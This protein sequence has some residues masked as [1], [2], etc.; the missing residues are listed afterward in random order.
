MQD[1][2]ERIKFPGPG[3]R[4][5][6]SMEDYLRVD[7]ISAS[8]LEAG[9]FATPRHVRSRLDRDTAFK[10]TDA[11]RVGTAVHLLVCEPERSGE[12]F[13]KVKGAQ[14][15]TTEEENPGKIIV[16][17][18]SIDTI[19]AM[20]KSIRD[21]PVVAGWLDGKDGKRDVATDRLIGIEREVCLFWIDERTGLR[22][23]ARMDL[24]IPGVLFTDIKTTSKIGYGAFSRDAEKRGYH[25][26]MWFYGQGAKTLD[27]DGIAPEGYIIAS[28]SDHPFCTAVYRYLPTALDEAE[29]Q[30]R[31]T[32]DLFGVCLASGVY[33]GYSEE[34]I[35]MDIPRYAYAQEVDGE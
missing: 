18:G 28:E 4:R 29:V 1:D 9:I 19:R 30:M 12:V 7:A 8:T 33:P 16:P 24:W 15:K 11:M 31:R 35:D 10:P 20:A 14:W 3:A 2:K 6:I 26:K 21:H 23:K 25:R 13:E 17:A 22:C 27:P 32:M 34:I 5:G